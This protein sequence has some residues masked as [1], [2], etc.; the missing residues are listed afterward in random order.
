LLLAATLP[1]WAV[2]PT[3]PRDPDLPNYHQVDDN[4]YR[5][6]QPTEE[7]FKALR[8]AGIKTVIDLRP[9]GEDSS[10]SVRKEQA[11]VEGQGMHYVNVPLSGVFAPSRETISKLLAMMTDAETGPVFIHCLRGADRTG[12]VIASYRIQH[13][14]WKNRD[15]L[16]EA[17]SLGMSWHE[18]AM[19]HFV[20]DF[21]PEASPGAPAALEAPSKPAL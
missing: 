12:T 16:H 14:H 3:L 9:D 13:D 11:I 6:A 17:D 4:V 20:S 5:G 21:R 8:K 19:K 1:G 15:A 18:V 10:H 2:G 7:G